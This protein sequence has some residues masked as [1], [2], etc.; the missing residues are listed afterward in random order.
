MQPFF[1]IEGGDCCGKSTAATTLLD[2]LSERG[3]PFFSTHAL[4]DHPE[5]VAAYQAM[6][7]R[8]SIDEVRD[9]MITAHDVL[10]KDIVIPQLK[11]GNVVVQDRNWL[12]T[13]NYQWMNHGLNPLLDE[14]LIAG[15]HRSYAGTKPFL[16]LLDGPDE[17]I[18][19]R[20]LSKEN[21]DTNESEALSFHENI[22]RNYRELFSVW[23]DWGYAG[24][25]VDSS[26]L[27][28]MSE[29]IDGIFRRVIL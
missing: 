25:V 10:T 21:K 6:C 26:T 17:I 19:Q 24:K 2:K 15:I 13:L 16:I 28:S 3:I 1:I 29:S 20:I 27:E 22:R 9:L 7:R 14:F 18:N 23:E 8:D 11:M 12:S 4:Y 5:G